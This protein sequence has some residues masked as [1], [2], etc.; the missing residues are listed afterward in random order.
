MASNYR[1]KSSQNQATLFQTWGYS[2]SNHQTA[3]ATWTKNNL[4]EHTSATEKGREAKGVK[5]KN[6]DQILVDDDLDDILE[7]FGNDDVELCQAVEVETKATYL[8]GD[9]N[10]RTSPEDL[11]GFDSS[12][13]HNYIYPVNY[14]VR[15]YQFKIIMKALMKNTLVVL[16]TGL[17]KTFIA[18]VVMYNFYRWYPLGKIIFM[19][20]TKPLVAQQIQACYNITGTPAEDTAEMTG[21]QAFSMKAVHAILIF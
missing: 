19:A 5:S 2:Q 11:P 4:K 6:G 20:P 16:P 10:P 17:G 8:D 18:A 1:S 9:F 21:K 15:E 7:C 12:S 14:P 3:T 13:G